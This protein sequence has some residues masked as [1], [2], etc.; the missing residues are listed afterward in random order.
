MLSFELETFGDL[1]SKY[2]RVNF[3][4]KQNIHNTLL[5]A[6]SKFHMLKDK[7]NSRGTDQ[8]NKLSQSE[9]VWLNNRIIAITNDFNSPK[10]K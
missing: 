2:Q 7:P 8:S 10:L 9:S 6:E 1:K 3:L 5:V 4:M